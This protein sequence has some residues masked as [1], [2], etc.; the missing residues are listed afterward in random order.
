MG[1][2]FFS[3]DFPIIGARTRVGVELR[4]QPGPASVQ[5]EYTRL[6]DERLGESV[7][8]TDLSPIRGRGWY[9][10]GTFAVTGDRK[11]RGLDATR[12]PIFR[13]GVGAVEV[14]ARL[15]R[16]T[17]D[18]TAVNDSLPSTSP[19]ADKILGNSD[20]ALT[21]GVNWY[22][23]RWVK[24]QFNTIKETLADP[25]QGPLADRPSFWSRVLRFQFSL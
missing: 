14:A 6:L 5:Y 8:D 24:I 17:F 23:N 4:W 21:L 25:E 2:R 22:L 15:E 19:R 10:S 9:L 20:R 3:S 7:E 13:G 16:L 12:H 1:N 18:S 11:S